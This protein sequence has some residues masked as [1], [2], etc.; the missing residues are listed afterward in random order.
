M[1]PVCGPLPWKPCTL[2]SGPRRHCSSENLVSVQTSLYHTHTNIHT[3]THTHKHIRNR[4]VCLSPLIF[5][6]DLLEVLFCGRCFQASSLISTMTSSR[7]GK[8]RRERRLVDQ[9]TCS[10]GIG[11]RSVFSPPRDLSHV[12]VLQILFPQSPMTDYS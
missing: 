12:N 3:H 11:N 8:N 10:E 7:K 4:H 2:L 5:H 6:T 9:P 1:E